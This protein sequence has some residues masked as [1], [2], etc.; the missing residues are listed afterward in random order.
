MAKKPADM[1]L[2]EIELELG[3]DEV[4][5]IRKRKLIELYELK[6]E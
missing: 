6:L 2:D 1:T 5:L 4:S 3:S